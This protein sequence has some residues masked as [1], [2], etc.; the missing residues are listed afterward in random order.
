MILLSI[1]Y[2]K[3]NRD[4][5]DRF[6]DLCSFFKDRDINIAMVES[7]IGNMHYLKCILKD[8]EKDIKAF[9]DLREMFYSYSSNIIYEFISKEYIADLLGKLLKDNYN[10]LNYPDI[11]EIDK[12]CMSVISGTG[13]FSTEGLLYSIT[14]KNNMVKRIGEYLQESSE[15]ILDGFI[16]FR[17]KDINSEL[18]KITEKVVEDYIIEKEYSEFIKLLKY[19]VEIQ[20]SKY[21]TIN[22][23]IDSKGQILV[24]DEKYHDIT[25]EFFEDF[26]TDNIKG[27]IN[28]NDILISALITCA[29]KKII[30]HGIG[31]MK[32]IEVMDTIKNIFSDKITFCGGCEVCKNITTVTKI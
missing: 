7:D 29:P 2:S 30:I 24:N 23:I 26:N 21:E 12:R 5:Y 8:A 14:C 27:E 18:N 15:M 3:N 19:F 1:G 4:I 28:K 9:D 11:E 6:K 20:E 17:M 13:M 25:L 32:D 10:Y 16:T 22:I 31:N